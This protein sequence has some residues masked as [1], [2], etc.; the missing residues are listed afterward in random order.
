MQKLCF[1][2][3][4]VH[5]VCLVLD[6][7]FSM[8]ISERLGQKRVNETYED[9]LKSRLRICPMSLPSYVIRGDAQCAV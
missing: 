4:F 8:S 5:S 1:F 7:K 9:W 6:L 2:Q 3:D